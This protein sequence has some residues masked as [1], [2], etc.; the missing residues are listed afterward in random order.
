MKPRTGFQSNITQPPAGPGC[1]AWPLEH[2]SAVPFTPPSVLAWFIS[3][4]HPCC[5]FPYFKPVL[6]MGSGKSMNSEVRQPGFNSSSTT[7]FLSLRFLLPKTGIELISKVVVKIHWD[8]YNSWQIFVISICQL[9]LWLLIRCFY[10]SSTRVTLA[11]WPVL[12]LWFCGIMSCSSSSFSWARCTV[13]FSYNPFA[14]SL[15]VGLLGLGELLLF[16]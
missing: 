12:F 7:G 11:P 15:G 10:F 16:Y 13:C 4:L 3:V 6:L 1:Q 5:L 2:L 14:S 8:E 9:L